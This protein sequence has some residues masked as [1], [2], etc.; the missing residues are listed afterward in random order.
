[1]CHPPLKLQSLRQKSSENRKL[2]R[3]KS[4]KVGWE[5]TKQQSE[6]KFDILWKNRRT[7]KP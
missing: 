2:L 7:E 3:F 4:L 1:M 6:W 5:N